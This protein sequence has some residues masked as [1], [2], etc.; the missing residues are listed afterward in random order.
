VARAQAA[1]APTSFRSGFSC[2][3]FAAVR[4]H[5][6]ALHAVGIVQ[7]HPLGVASAS[8]SVVVGLEARPIQVEVCSSRGPAFFQLVGL[9]EAAVREARV[10]VASSL[11][12]LD[13]LLD[14]YAITVNLAPADLRKAGATLDLAIALAVLVAIG[15]IEQRALT[16]TLLLGELGL[17]GSLRPVRGLLPQLDGARQRGIQRAVVPAANAREAGIAQ[18]LDVRL[19]NSLEEVVESLRSGRP[20]PPAERTRFV[21]TPARTSGDLSEVR[22]QATARRALEIAAAGGHNLLLIGPPGSGKTLLARLLPGILPPLEFDEAVECTSIHSVAGLLSPELGI[23]TER[24]FRAPHHSVSEAGLVGGGDVPRPGE[25]SLAHNGVLF[26]DELA[27]FRRGTLEA[28]R[29]PLEDGTVCIARARARAWFPA[30][31]VLVGAVNPCPCGYFSHPRRR[32]LCSEEARKRYR[33]RLSGPLIDRLDIHVSVPPVDVTALTAARHGESS[34][35]VRARV[36]RARETQRRRRDQLE[37]SARFNAALSNAELERVAVLGR[38]ARRLLELA[39]NK[40]GLSARAFV[41]VLRVARTIADLEDDE[42]IRQPHV[43]EAIQGRLL[44]REV[45]R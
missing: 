1:I 5:V 6:E 17:D 12:R 20:L 13:I 18:G 3:T 30:R 33:A 11:A 21:A 28:L 2:G 15:T 41:K 43:A 31:P 16:G 32:C 22:G 39:V 38:D 7:G 14:E 19:A 27:E 25:V 35:S 40:L 10:R 45:P 44:D 36:T 37:V 26:L 34:E 8:A 9:A 23:L 4:P 24:P 29:Q 42:R